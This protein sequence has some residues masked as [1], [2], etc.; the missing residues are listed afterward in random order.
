[1]I[2]VPRG[3]EDVPAV[4]LDPRGAAARERKKAEE[5]FSVERSE[6][7][8]QSFPFSVYSDPEIKDALD[9]LFH[10]K[11]AYCEAKY[12]ETQPMDVEHWRPKARILEED[13]ETYSTGYYWLASDWMNLLPSCI[14]CNRERMQ[15]DAAENREQPRGK[16]ERFPLADPS[17]RAK[18]KGAEND[19]SP[20]LLHPCKDDPEEHLAIN[21]M[22]VVVP[23]V[24]GSS[25]SARGKASIAVYGLNRVGLVD[26]RLQLLQLMQHRFAAI[27]RLSRMLDRVANPHLASTIEDL[28][29]HEIVELKRFADSRRPFSLM[30]RQFLN[31]CAAQ[32]EAIGERSG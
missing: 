4:L 29:A 22:A 2:K 25:P 31:R 20:L 30:V 10:G 11:C 28:I 6:T 9:R 15:T 24:V 18:T 8:H 12:A 5:F 26:E 1:M 21:D 13:G 19:E 14:D 17:R 32:L 3:E 27:L 16:G 7:D 23:R